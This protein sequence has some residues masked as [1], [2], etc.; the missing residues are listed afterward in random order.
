MQAWK[1]DRRTW[2]RHIEML[3]PGMDRAPALSMLTRPGMPRLVYRLAARSTGPAI[4][5]GPVVRTVRRT[6][7]T[8]PPMPDLSRNPQPIRSRQFS[9]VDAEASCSIGRV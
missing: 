6:P 3:S 9:R 4:V 1:A 8:A 5:A 7:V 2:H